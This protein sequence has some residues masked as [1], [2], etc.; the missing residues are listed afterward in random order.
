MV[1]SEDFSAGKDKRNERDI[2][3]FND[4]T[5]MSSGGFGEE[6][7]SRENTEFPDRD[8]RDDLRAGGRNSSGSISATHNDIFQKEATGAEDAG[9]LRDIDK[10]TPTMSSHPSNSYDTDSR[11]EMN[12]QP[13]SGLTAASTRFGDEFTERDN[14]ILAGKKSDAWVEDEASR[15]SAR[16]GEELGSVERNLYP[17]DVTRATITDDLTDDNDA[18]TNRSGTITDPAGEHTNED[19]NLWEKIKDKAEDIG[20]GIKKAFD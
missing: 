2:S 7:V 18:L 11:Q 1:E 15:A 14:D 10:D 5:K 20:E 9:T 6:N 16:F 13:G 17:T 12:A 8:M 19:K 3:N 4:D